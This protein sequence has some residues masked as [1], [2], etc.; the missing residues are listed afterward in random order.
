[1]RNPDAL[2]AALTGKAERLSGKLDTATA[3][4]ELLAAQVAQLQQEN[5]AEKARNAL[6]QAGVTDPEMLAALLPGQVAREDPTAVPA[7]LV[8][9]LIPKGLPPSRSPSNGTPSSTKSVMEQ[10]REPLI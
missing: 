9:K 5:A 8:E 3:A 10:M 4:T 7:S 6:L 1:V 2:I